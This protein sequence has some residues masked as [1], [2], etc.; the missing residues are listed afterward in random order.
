MQ[1]AFMKDITMEFEKCHVKCSI[2]KNEAHSS[3]NLN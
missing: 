1:D 2:S 3:S